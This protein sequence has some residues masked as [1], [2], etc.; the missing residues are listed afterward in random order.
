MNARATFDDAA[1]ALVRE[2][3]AV[4]ARARRDIEHPDESG[5]IVRLDRPTMGLVTAWHRR[6]L[7]SALVIERQ[8]NYLFECASLVDFPEEGPR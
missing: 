5:I 8:F 4:A 1:A 7:D 6:W 2:I 3:E